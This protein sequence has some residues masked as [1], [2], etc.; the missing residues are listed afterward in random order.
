MDAR[1][2]ESMYLYEKVSVLRV[3]V[4]GDFNVCA[5]RIMYT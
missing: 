2:G 3:S 1:A 5:L 4:D